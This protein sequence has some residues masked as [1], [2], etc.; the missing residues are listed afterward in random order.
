MA[1]VTRSPIRSVSRSPTGNVEAVEQPAATA[2][3]PADKS[4][5]L[6]LSGSNLIATANANGAAVRSSTSYATGK[7]YAEYLINA[8]TGGQDCAVGIGT[9]LSY[10]GEDFNLYPGV[11]DDESAVLY[12]HATAAVLAANGSNVVAYGV[13]AGASAV[14]RLAVDIPGR[15]LW[16]ALGAGNWNNSPA[17]DPATGAGGVSLVAPTL[18]RFYLFM[19]AWPYGGASPQ[20]TMRPKASAFGYAIPD[21][22]TAWGV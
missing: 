7:R 11:G 22:F 20:A 15:Q 16:M 12:C 5:N 3:N 10:M 19:R 2:W 8:F 4:A 17:A 6:A 1:S 21:G 14:I 9:A 18:S 13:G